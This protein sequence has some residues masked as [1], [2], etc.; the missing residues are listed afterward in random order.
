MF[1]LRDLPRLFLSL[2]RSTAERELRARLELAQDKRDA[3]WT[4]L[5]DAKAR[6]RDLETENRRLRAALAMRP[7]ETDA[8]VQN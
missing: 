1:R 3:M 5:Q 2:W 8:H 7:K 6:V 4:A